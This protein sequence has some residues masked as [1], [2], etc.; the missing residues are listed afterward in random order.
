[1]AN[2]YAIG[3]DFTELR[4]KTY[5]I[6]CFYGAGNSYDAV[7]L[8]ADVYDD[9][10][11]YDDDISD[12][13]AIFEEFVSRLTSKYGSCNG[14]NTI[15]VVTDDDF[16]YEGRFGQAFFGNGLLLVE[17]EG[18]N[19]SFQGCYDAFFEIQECMCR[20]GIKVLLD[21]PSEMEADFFYPVDVRL[22]PDLIPG[23]DS[24][25]ITPLPNMDDYSN[26]FDKTG[27]IHTTDGELLYFLN[28]DVDGISNDE[29]SDSFE[30][31]LFSVKTKEGE[32]LVLTTVP[33]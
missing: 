10:I 2:N 30:G 22:L 1:M 21:K 8:A 11:W 26:V 15:E 28:D 14:N 20:C 6:L 31:P 17:L 32:Q 13:E 25:M 23:F 27:V 33:L 24:D 12:K 19:T 29:Y 18:D 5:G 4:P 7:Q 9:L 16:D 3:I